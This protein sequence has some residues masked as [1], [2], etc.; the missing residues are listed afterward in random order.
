MTRPW[1]GAI[2]TMSALSLACW[3]AAATIARLRGHRVRRRVAAGHRRRARIGPV[4]ARRFIALCRGRSR[5]LTQLDRQRSAHLPE[6]VG[7]IERSLVSGAS[8][9][10]AIQTAA[11]VVG[12][13]LE[14]E[15]RLLA[16]RVDAGSPFHVAVRR[17]AEEC[18]SDDVALLAAA[19]DLGA[20]MGCGTAS[21][22]AGVATTL[23]SRREIGHEATAAAAQSRASVWLLTLLPG[24]F[25]VGTVAID[26]RVL[27]TLVWTPAG[28]ACMVVATILDLAG[29]AWMHLQ[30]RAAT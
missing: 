1:V 25:L 13:P 27:T 9:D 28:W 6:L 23:A 20:E 19:C 4:D 15:L 21:A 11:G 8:L 29:M 26:R 24:V 12:G 16:R 22:L 10:Q 17:W 30:I 5:G 18:G 2:V 3:G 7:S 14:P